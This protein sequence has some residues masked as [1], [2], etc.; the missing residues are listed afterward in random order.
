MSVVEMTMTEFQSG[1]PGRRMSIRLKTVM[2]G[3]DTIDLIQDD[4]DSRR[5]QRVDSGVTS[6]GAG[7]EADSTLRADDSSITLLKRVRLVWTP[8]LHKRIVEVVG[9]L[10]VKNVVPKTIMQM[11]NVEGLTRENVATHLQKY[12]LY[13]KQMHGSSNEGPSSSDPLFASAV[14]PKRFHESD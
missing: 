10:G 14:V 3:E 7:G 9:H 11:M 6:G 12:R 1:R 4:S 2:E 8:Q 5:L 13:V